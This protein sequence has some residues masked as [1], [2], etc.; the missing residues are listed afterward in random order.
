MVIRIVVVGQR[1]V[2]IIT[3][4][5][6][7]VGSLTTTLKVILAITL[8]HLQLGSTFRMTTEFV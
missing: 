1:V 3:E 2:S 7:W 6:C 5:A 8:C 4:V